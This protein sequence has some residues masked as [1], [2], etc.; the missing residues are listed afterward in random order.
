MKWDHLKT[1]AEGKY[2]MQKS[3]LVQL[4]FRSTFGGLG[5]LVLKHWEH[6]T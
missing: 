6:P 2:E 5:H 3:F 1:L 4:K